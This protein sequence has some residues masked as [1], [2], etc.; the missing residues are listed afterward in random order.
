MCI[1]LEQ[2]FFINIDN[3]T[4]KVRKGMSILEAALSA[5]IY[6][7][8]LC[9]HP[10]LP[11]AG[12]C[13]M[14]I[15]E[16][17]GRE[18]IFTSCTTLAEEGMVVKTKTDRLR[19]VRNLS[20][21]L[22]LASHPSECTACP[23][24]LK[25]EL[26]NLIQ[27]LGVSGARVRKLPVAHPVVTENPL[28]VRDLNRCI[29]CGRC[30]R[31]CRQ[32]RGCEVLTY[33]RD[34]EKTYIG[35]EH[36]GLLADDNC[37]FC[38]ACVEVCPTG[39]LMDKAEVISKFP[40]TE[41]NLLP[42]KASCPA[43]IDVPGYVRLIKEGKYTE[44]VALISQKA[45]FPLTL[46]YICTAFCEANCRRRYVNNSVAI[47]ELKKFAALRD[48][49]L[50]KASSK[51]APPTGKKIAVIGSGP[52]GLTAAYYLAKKGHDVT[53]FEK[54]PYPGGMMRVGI[55]EYRL[56]R[57][58][59]ETEIKE[60][61]KAGVKIRTNSEIKAPGGLLDEGYAAVLAAIGTH[62]GVRLPIAGNDLDCVLVNTDF[63]RDISLHRNVTVGERV[64]VLGGG[65]VAFDCARSARRLGA[66][67]VTI[68]CLEDR[69]H[70]TA[71]I[72]EIE[73]GLEEGIVILNSRTFSRIVSE[74]GSAV[75]VCSKVESFYFDENR[76]LILNTV[77]GLEHTIQADTVIFATG[78][79]VDIPEGFGL[80]TGRGNLITVSN[81][82]TSKKGVFAAGD[83]I[84][85]TSSVI[86]AIASG[87]GAATAIDRYLGGDGDIDE[88][89]APLEE[90]EQFI[91]KEEKFA[92]RE[93]Q[94]ACCAPV[95]E[96]ISGFREYMQ[97]YDE[98]MAHCESERCLQCDLRI[99]M[100]KVKFWGD[101]THK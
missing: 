10:N 66:K 56:P 5:D 18:G 59:F 87:R 16:I 69:D 28:F 78:Q 57:E 89:L 15:V 50:W 93:R 63:L 85:G 29:L 100:D 49:G 51:I 44:A 24:Y 75:V 27:Y 101:Y 60:I 97:P 26:Q 32:L 61:E 20:M 64:L 77:P 21:E 81:Y 62:K 73:E 43:G 86:Q 70:M 11:D 35:T 71:S 4:V 68:A 23:K 7:P 55:P 13:K 17:E 96:R 92:Y 12:E 98:N 58:V 72:A 74:N 39:A 25:C 3:K 33:V 84:S 9:H 76:K 1:S 19:H 53:V 54:Q 80:S 95:G 88:I 82:E 8:H 94:I 22:M 6:I 48:N 30:V 52:A 99:K 65:N 46:G 42:C 34:N 37:R 14:C 40:K 41:D 91:G 38:T 47:R 83:A 67:E 36:G 79:T 90:P 2:F 31:A 45:P